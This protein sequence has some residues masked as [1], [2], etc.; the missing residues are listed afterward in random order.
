V[1]VGQQLQS[2]QTVVST[3]SELEAKNK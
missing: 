1:T 3:I 2:N